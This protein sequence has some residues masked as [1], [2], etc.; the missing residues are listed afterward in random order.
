M[1]YTALFAKLFGIFFLSVGV[2]AVSGGLDIKKM[3]KSFS[4][5]QGLTIMSGFMMI[6]LGGFMVD[7]H[8]IWVKDWPVAVTVLAWAT[9]FKG[10]T[11][12]AFP[13]LIPAIGLKFK[14]APVKPLSL[15]IL[16]I[17]VLYCYIGFAL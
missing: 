4:D 5:S 3:L 7:T 10:I 12:I 11:F 8:N 6:A 17:G 9:L 15:L 16:A 2:L 1:E 14:K 13:N